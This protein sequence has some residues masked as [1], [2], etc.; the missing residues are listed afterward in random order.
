VELAFALDAVRRYGWIIVVCAVLGAIPGLLGGREAAPQ[1]ES[2]AI[3]ILSPA[4]DVRTQIS[5]SGANERYVLGQIE[6]LR[7][8]ALA[9]RVATRLGDVAP[10]GVELSSVAHDPQTDVVALVVR[11]DTAERAEAVAAGYAEAYLELLTEQV[12]TTR[13]PQLEDIAVELEQL[14]VELA[15]IDAAIAAAMEP[16]LERATSTELAAAVPTVEQVVPELFSERQLVVSKFLDLQAAQT[17][18]Q[19][20]SPFVVATEIIEP[21]TPASAVPAG[22]SRIL[23]AAGLM[24]GGLIGVFITLVAGRFSPRL[25][26]PRH[27][28]E[29]LGVHV[30]GPIGLGTDRSASLAGSRSLAEHAALSDIRAN[31]E[32]A[33]D[34]DD[35]RFVLV[36]DAIPGS[37]S[38]DVALAVAATFALDGFRTVLVEGDPADHSVSDELVS[39]SAAGGAWLEDGLAPTGQK[40]MALYTGGPKGTHWLPG[41]VGDLDEAVG[42]VAQRVV[43]AA[44]TMGEG[45]LVSVLADR[46][47]LVVV[48]V[49]RQTRT[50]AL[51]LAV[52]RLRDRVPRV[53]AVWIDV[54]RRRIG[55]GRVGAAPDAT[56]V[57]TVAVDNAPIDERTPATTDKTEPEQ[58]VS[59]S[60]S[61]RPP[62]GDRSGA[63][64]PIRRPSSD[65]RG[66]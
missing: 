37:G 64:Q 39:T 14:R 8:S 32:S 7:S 65:R 3:V 49:S 13:S 57:A 10:G 20:G 48:V 33:S 12:D 60:R 6:V 66:G 15:D 1:Y 24:L 63:Q 22:P 5:L 38:T 56:S 55:T 9:D 26:S 23:A 52:A 36:V 17:Q 54:P 34:R 50:S 11:A 2:R 45:N 41:D 43:V 16:F 59:R 51:D 44:G 29:L 19:V 58:S 53:V 62:G 46:S 47:T 35:P 40:M 31:V 25:L 28:E 4:R 61:P 27:A 18:L 21:A 30:L 42:S